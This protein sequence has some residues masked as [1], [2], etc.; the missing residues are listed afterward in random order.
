[1]MEVSTEYISAACNQ[2][3]HSLALNKNDR[4]LIYAASNTIVQVE[5]QHDRMVAKK[6]VLGHTDRVNCVRWMN[7]K[8]FVSGAT[9]KKVCIWENYKLIQTLSGHQGSVTVVDGLFDLGII[10][11]ASTDSTLKIWKRQTAENWTCIQTYPC[12]ANGFVL[13]IALLAF[14]DN[15]LWIFASLDDCSVRLFSMCQETFLESHVLKG[16]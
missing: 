8:C 9:D 7:D 1:M 2:V 4:S 13:D 16:N 3:P 14:P 12:P 15:S 10:V 6:S 5:I 11:S